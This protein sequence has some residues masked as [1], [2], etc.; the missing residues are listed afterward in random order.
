MKGD[1]FEFFLQKRDL[2]T[3]TNPGLLGLWGGGVE[4]GES[5]EA[6]VMREVSEELSYSPKQMT[7]YTHFESASNVLDVFIEEVGEEFENVVTIGEGEYG[8]FLKHDQ[9]FFNAEV[10]LQAQFVIHQFLKYEKK[11]L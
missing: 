9:I 11:V 1:T 10:T 4:E 2:V 5:I 8:I 7:Y 3:K 6:A